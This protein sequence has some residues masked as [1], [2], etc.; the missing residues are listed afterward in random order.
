MHRVYHLRLLDNGC[1]NAFDRHEPWASYRIWCRT[2]SLVPM[3]HHDG[4][5]RSFHGFV[6]LLALNYSRP[7]NLC[8]LG[9]DGLGRLHFV[10]FLVTSGFMGFV[11]SA[12]LLGWHDKFLRVFVAFVWRGSGGRSPGR[13]GC[14]SGN[15]PDRGILEHVVAAYHKQW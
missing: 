4:D 2:T 6:H 13:S 10:D 12:V 7:S 3:R 11:G 8:P 14:P 15:P 9:L 1:C 5:R